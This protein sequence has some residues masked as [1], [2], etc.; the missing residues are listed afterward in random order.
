[1]RVLG[2]I[3]ADNGGYNF[4]LNKLLADCPFVAYALCSAYA[5]IV[6]MYFAAFARRACALYG[7]FSDEKTPFFGAFF[8]YKI[9]FL[10]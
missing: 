5:F 2:G 3:I 10:F 8:A 9:L 6:V 7:F 4:V 1:M